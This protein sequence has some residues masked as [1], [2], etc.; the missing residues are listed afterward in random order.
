MSNINN[1]FSSVL[2]TSGR[3]V[4][5]QVVDNDS[6]DDGLS[7]SSTVIVRMRKGEQTWIRVVKGDFLKATWHSVS[8]SMFSG[9]KIN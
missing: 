4:A 9:F 2:I 3:R 8:V 7:S 5:E 1:D 6:T